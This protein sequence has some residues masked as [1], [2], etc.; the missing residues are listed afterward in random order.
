MAGPGIRYWEFARHL[1]READVVLAIPNAPSAPG[2]GF[3]VERYTSRRLWR[4]VRA[5]DVVVCQGFRFPLALL[6]LAGKIVVVDLYD[7]LPLELLE[8]YRDASRRD[9]QFAQ[10]RVALRL[11]R[12]CRLGDLF[13]CTS[14]RQRDFWLGA[15]A[16]AGRLNWDTY[17]GDPRL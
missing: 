15:L 12:L 3:R 14:P 5:A 16:V 2:D 13:L 8:Y 17:R 7:P 4:L 6:Q 9:A 11:G 1:A 10:Q